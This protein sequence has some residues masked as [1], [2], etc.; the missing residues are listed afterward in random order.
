[1]QAGYPSSSGA[2]WPPSAQYIWQ[3]SPTSPPSFLI[4]GGEKRK[5]T[6][7]SEAQYSGLDA[8]RKRQ[9]RFQSH[10]SFSDSD[11]ADDSPKTPYNTIDDAMDWA[12][13]TPSQSCSLPPWRNPSPSQAIHRLELLRE[14]RP[15]TITTFTAPFQRSPYAR[16]PPPS[17][18][19]PMSLESTD[20]EYIFRVELPGYNIDNITVSCKRGNVVTVVA[21][22]WHLPRECCHT[23]DIT[24]DSD[25]NTSALR[26]TMDRTTSILTLTAKRYRRY[27][28]I[29]Y[30]VDRKPTSSPA[31]RFLNYES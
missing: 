30:Q 17:K 10:S 11:D 27:V 7:H 31:P 23:W 12:A 1:M 8:L 2:R 14:A 18:A 29:E 26:A 16:E 25:V 5:L 19:V 4:R 28:P 6:D 21:D 20:H 22:I 24:F 13:D 9:R 3:P 15:P